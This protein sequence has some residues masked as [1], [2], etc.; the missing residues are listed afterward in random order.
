M[1]IEAGVDLV[2]LIGDNLR[3]LRTQRGLSL[4]RLAKASGVSRG[5]LSQIEL[6]RSAPTVNVLWKIGRALDL[7]FLTLFK[8]THTTTVLRKAMA[9]TLQSPDQTFSCRALFP[10]DHQRKVEF[11]ELQLDSGATALSEPHA[12]GTRENLAVSQGQIEVE[13]H[14]RIH[15]L[16]QGDSIVFEAD[17]PHVYRNPG[18]ESGLYYLVMTYAESIG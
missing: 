8:Q 15:H 16:D 5:M 7:N 1:D 9:K 2:G 18:A 3:R 4:D 6:G 12:P 14:G 11:Y 17:Q 10:F 13:V